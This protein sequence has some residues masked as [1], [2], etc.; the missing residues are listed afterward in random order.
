MLNYQTPEQ[1]AR[2]SIDKQLVVCGL[3]VQS[4]SEININAGIDEILTSYDITE[5]RNFKAW[6]FKKQAGNLKFTK[7]QMDWLFML[8]D[9]IGSSVHVALED[10]DYAPF[11]ASGGRGRMWQLFGGSMETILAELNEALAA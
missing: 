6:L 7:E 5:D 2:D 9:Q 1:I 8:K 3:V 11:E 10:L 4:K